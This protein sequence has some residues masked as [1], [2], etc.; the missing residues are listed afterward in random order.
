V[1]EMAFALR[2]ASV[3]GWSLL[4]GGSL[5]LGHL[6]YGGI[7]WAGLLVFG[8]FA[9]LGLLPHRF[10]MRHIWLFVLVFLLS[11]IPFAT[12]AYALIRMRFIGDEPPW[13][14]AVL[15]F[16]LLVAVLFVL[17]LPGSLG[18]SFWADYIARRRHAANS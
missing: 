2:L 18:V 11:L 1:K 10:L 5:I 9:G 14:F 4:I 13:Y 7:D 8:G 3:A 15:A 6:Q 12:L 16:S 17:L